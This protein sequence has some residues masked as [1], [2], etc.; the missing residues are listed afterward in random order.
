M[1]GLIREMLKRLMG[2]AAGVLAVVSTELPGAAE[3]L[4]LRPVAD[5]TLFESAPG[6][7]MGAHSHVAIGVTALGST[8]RGLFRFDLSS[9]PTNT[10]VE[11]VSLTFHLQAINRPDNAGTLHAVHRVTREWF[12][13]SKSGNQGAPATAGE[14]TWNHNALP[15][16]WTA[17]GEI[18]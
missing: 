12:E 15:T 1:A 5:T 17:A 13:G 10:V 7:N 2:P 6:N 3:Q 4:E 9:L 18:S 8:A 16:L 14:A 11:S